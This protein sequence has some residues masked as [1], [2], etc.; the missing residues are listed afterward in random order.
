[1]ELTGDPVILLLGSVVVGGFFAC[2]A[3]AAAA[4]AVFRLINK[5]SGT[6]RVRQIG[7]IAEPDVGHIKGEHDF[8]AR[9]IKSVKLNRPFFADATNI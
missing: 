7:R 1:M 9:K 4:A 5:V 6:A 2:V 3:A 8:P